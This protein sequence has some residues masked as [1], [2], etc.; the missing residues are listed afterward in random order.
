MKA[1][2]INAQPPD[3]TR[4]WSPSLVE[5]VGTGLPRPDPVALLLAEQQRDGAL[6]R[7]LMCAAAAVLILVVG[8]GALS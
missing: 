7:L 6:G 3:D 5:A 1:L 2:T 8:A 4:L